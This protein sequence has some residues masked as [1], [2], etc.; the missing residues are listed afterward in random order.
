M[1][2]AHRFGY[3]CDRACQL[4]RHGSPPSVVGARHRRTYG[5][6]TVA[7]GGVNTFG[8]GSAPGVI[9]AGETAPPGLTRRDERGSRP[10]AAAGREL[11]SVEPALVASTT[12]RTRSR[13]SSSR[14]R[15]ATCVLTVS[16]PGTNPAVMRRR[17]ERCGCSGSRSAQSSS[18][19]WVNG[20]KPPRL[21]SSTATSRPAKA[22]SAVTTVQR[23]RRAVAAMRRSNGSVRVGGSSPTAHA[24]SWVTVA[25]VKP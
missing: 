15:R 7:C 19:R 20:Q 11:G 10:S 18:A 3:R 5:S 8:E 23:R 16:W 22:G 6:S 17:R 25:S 24:S 1:G 2:Q 9:P 21:G 13:R 14:R 12:A 4:A